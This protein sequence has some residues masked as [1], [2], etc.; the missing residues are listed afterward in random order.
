LPPL[1]GS[2]FSLMLTIHIW[3]LRPGRNW[4]WV[5]FFSALVT[6][7]CLGDLVWVGIE[8]RDT[9]VLVNRLQYLPISLVPA[10]W[11]V[12]AL[13]KAGH[14]LTARRLLPSLLLIPAVT[15]YLAWQFDPNTGNALWR[16]YLM[17]PQVPLGRVEYGPWFW[18]FTTYNYLL[19]L[20]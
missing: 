9:A 18:V 12:L 2:L 13:G 8:E 15:L 14:E 19:I 1:L 4:G 3:L 7:W 6:L 5:A 11:L 17:P 16:N 10:V 20:L